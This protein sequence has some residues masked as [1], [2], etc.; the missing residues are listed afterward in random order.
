MKRKNSV[1]LN[2]LSIALLL[3]AQGSL[4]A[5]SGWYPLQSGTSNILNSVYFVDANTGYMAGDGIILKSTNSGNN[6]YVIT[7]QYGGK[8]V[9]FT[10]ALIGYVCDGTVYKTLNGGVSWYNLQLT[11]IADVFFHNNIIGYAVGKN[12][13]ILK[14]IDGGGSWQVQSTGQTSNKFND[15]L[16]L[17]E[18][19][20]FIAGGKANA[21]YTGVI[22]KTTNG[23][24]IWNAVLTHAPDVEFR[25]I[26]FVNA[27]TGFAV[28]GNE[29]ASNG[30]IYKTNNGGET[31]IQWGIVNKDLNAV[32]FASEQ[33]GY[34]VGEDGMILKT[35][36]GGVVW[37]TQVSSTTKDIHS[38]HFLMENLGYTA[39]ESGNVQKT[40]NGGVF[41]PPFGISG[42]VI[43]PGGQ[44]VTSGYV[45]ALKYNAGTNT[46]QILDEA[47]IQSNGDYVLPNIGIDSVDVMAYPNDED[48]DNPLVPAFVPTYYGVGNQ[49]TI[50]WTES[51]TLYPTGNL[52]N[53]NVTVY[54]VNNTGGSLFIGGGVYKAPPNVVVL[55]GSIVYAMSGNDFKGYG[56]SGSNGLY[57]VDL[58]SNGNYRMICDR[59]GY[60]SAERNVTLGSVSL[61][62]I[63]FYMTDIGIIGIEP[64]GSQIP[65]AFNLDQNYPNPFNPVTNIN[66][67]IPKSA[68]VKLAV[69]DMLGRELEVLVNENLQAGSYK[70]TWNAVK[71]SSGIYFYKVVSSDYV[72]TKKM[73]LV[74]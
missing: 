63:N 36:N 37:N 70:V 30:V 33:I 25:G 52:F 43:L 62:T 32:Y 9:F 45:R 40:Q 58:L 1:I 56:I 34:A 17:T 38:V 51:N 68:Y 2:V 4:F 6:W 21:P 72:A 50:H 29:T 69:Y 12:D 46:I 67:D 13:Q 31:W 64:I 26:D 27:M 24:V 8:S 14:T 53:V 61:D 57:D 19:V 66:V 16:F 74:K 49:P 60:H 54:P 44:A 41:G 3:F 28:G 23:G 65:K 18:S 47:I 11:S 15:V 48:E 5:Q 59:F 71:Y 22:Y 42:K 10:D 39:G 7:T 35:I 55:P 73:I 20:G